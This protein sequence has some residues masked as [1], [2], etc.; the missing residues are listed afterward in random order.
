M[1]HRKPTKKRN[2]QKRRNEGLG[3]KSNKRRKI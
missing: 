1:G 3:K 2:R